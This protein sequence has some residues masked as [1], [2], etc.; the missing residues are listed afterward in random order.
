MRSLVIDVWTQLLH[1]R[2]SPRRDGVKLRL[3]DK[4]DC[5]QGLS[6]CRGVKCVQGLSVP[7]FIEAIGTCV[8]ED[9]L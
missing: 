7:G 2:W 4:S 1:E 3:C 8:H 5:V 9:G 6:A